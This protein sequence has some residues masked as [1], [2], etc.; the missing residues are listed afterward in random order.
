MVNRSF[1]AGAVVALVGL[2]AFH[3]F[4]KPLPGAKS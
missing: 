1:V 2:W 4:V 3:H